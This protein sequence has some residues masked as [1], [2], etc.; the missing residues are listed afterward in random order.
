MDLPSAAVE[1]Q[2]PPSQDKVEGGLPEDGYTATSSDTQI[3]AEPYQQFNSYE[4][5]M[6]GATNFIYYGTPNPAR[7]AVK[8]NVNPQYGMWPYQ[9]KFNRPEWIYDKTVGVG[10]KKQVNSKPVDLIRLDYDEGKGLH[11]NVH[12]WDTKTQFRVEK[13]KFAALF[14]FNPPATTDKEKDSQFKALVLKLQEKTG[15][16]LWDA[17][18]HGRRP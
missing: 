1:E 3:L 16:Q 2:V 13:D 5:A 10:I 7:G 11:F 6:I 12:N 14:P 15:N 9:S 4:D 18:T 17:W 8:R